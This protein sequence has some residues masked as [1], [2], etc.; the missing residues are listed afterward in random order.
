MLGC[1]GAALQAGLLLWCFMEVLHFISNLFRVNA[2]LK[3]LFT[4]ALCMLYIMIY[5]MGRV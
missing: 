1:L 3:V 5:V 2:P 4:T